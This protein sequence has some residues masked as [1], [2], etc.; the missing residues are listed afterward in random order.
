MC[1]API[2]GRGSGRVPGSTAQPLEAGA[3]LEASAPWCTRPLFSSCLAHKQ[4]FRGW[5]LTAF[6]ADHSRVLPASPGAPGH[7]HHIGSIHAT[8]PWP[9]TGCWALPPDSLLPLGWLLQPAVSSLVG[10]CGPWV[11]VLRASVV[12]ALLPRL[13][14]C[15]VPF[16]SVQMAVSR[17]ASLKNAPSL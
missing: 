11:C 4:R 8:F 12:R 15:V 14:A 17:S 16:M 6:P 5:A 10:S 13:P 2:T 9:C 1:S 3:P 7:L